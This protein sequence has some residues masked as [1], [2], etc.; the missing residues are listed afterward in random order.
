[1]PYFAVIRE[2]GPAW[3]WSV[4]MRRTTEFELRAQPLRAMCRGLCFVLAGLRGL[5][6]YGRSRRPRCLTIASEEERRGRRCPCGDFCLL[7]FPAGEDWEARVPLKR[8]LTVT[9]L[10]SSRFLAFGRL[11]GTAVR[12]AGGFLLKKRMCLEL[13]KRG[14]LAS[15]ESGRDGAF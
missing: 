10:N 11:R 5:P 15:D 9:F 6:P 13:V 4:P 8:Q 2:R 14:P 12:R 7:V 1:M 3:D